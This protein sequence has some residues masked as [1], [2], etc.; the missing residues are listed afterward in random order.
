MICMRPRRTFLI[1]GNNLLHAARAHDPERPVGRLVLC[2]RLG[3]WA[4]RYR[5]RVRIVFDG[6]A[7]A[8]GL[9]A[10]IDESQVEVVYSG[11]ETSAD[12]VLLDLLRREAR[13]PRL[14][15]V[16]SDRQI[17]RAAR[18]RRAQSIRS[19]AFWARVLQDIARPPPT[20][21]DP[22]HKR[23]GLTAEQTQRW[24]E[25]LGLEDLPDDGPAI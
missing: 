16:S 13:G 2:H 9:A 11:A 22:L 19:D 20:S 1:D 12:D 15:V 14:A 5:H 21:P 10:Q 6:P 4:K 25:E 3:A 8:P 7:P 24:I 18:A 17:V 23:R